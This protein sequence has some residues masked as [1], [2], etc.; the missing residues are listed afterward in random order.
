MTKLQKEAYELYVHEG[1]TQ[2]QIAI[3]IFN[4]K[5]RQGDVS[6]ALR[7]ISKKLGLPESEGLTKIY[8]KGR[9]NQEQFEIEFPNNF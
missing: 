8:D 7:S 6:R 5:Y 3:K 1:L 2:E 9:K 4:D